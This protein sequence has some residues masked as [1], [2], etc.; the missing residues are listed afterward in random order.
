MGL[1]VARWWHIESSCRFF[2][3]ESVTSFVCDGH[4]TKLLFIEL[5]ER[6]VVDNIVMYSQR[7]QWSIWHGADEE[8]C[9]KAIASVR[10]IWASYCKLSKPSPLFG[11]TNIIE[12]E[13]KNLKILNCLSLSHCAYDGAIK[14]RQQAPHYEQPKRKFRPMVF[15][16]SVI[17]FANV[18]DSQ[19]EITPQEW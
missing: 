4:R 6:N 15:S 7:Q 13:A 2:W 3:V 11:R 8:R 10:M 5:V 14:Q 19:M 17:W 18:M 16:V 12:A 9:G 1:V